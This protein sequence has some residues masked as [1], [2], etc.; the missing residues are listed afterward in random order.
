M[1]RDRER[2]RDRP[3]LVLVVM[4][5]LITLLGT[6]LFNFG[7]RVFIDTNPVSNFDAFASGFAEHYAFFGKRHNWAQVTANFSKSVSTT[8]RPSALFATFSQ[9]IAPLHDVHA[10]V[11]MRSG[12]RSF[13]SGRTRSGQQARLKMLDNL[14]WI[15][16]AAERQYFGGQAATIGNIWFGLSPEPAKR[17]GYV[18]VLQMRASNATQSNAM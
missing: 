6:L 16:G 14:P 18:G 3:V 1:G 5:V 10:S 4:V 12:I 8:T 17:W 13:N 7:G 11:T 9:M 2:A 15:R